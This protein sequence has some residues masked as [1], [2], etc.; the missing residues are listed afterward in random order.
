MA[1]IKHA[2]HGFDID[3]PGKDS[4]RLAQ[5]GCDIVVISSPRGMAL[6][7]KRAEEASLEEL[8]SLLGRQADI[9]LAEG[10]KDSSKAKIE[11]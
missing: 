7:Q 1:A 6:I 10:Y 11:I 4:W 3:K 9:I 2:S 8:T 5:A